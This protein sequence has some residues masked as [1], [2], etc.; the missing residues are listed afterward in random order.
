MRLQGFPALGPILDRRGPV[1]RLAAGILGPASRPVRAILF[2]KS[3]AANWSLGWHQDRVIVV[4]DRIEVE[5]FGPWTIKAGLLH[6]MPPATILGSMLT[7]RVHLDPVAATN[8]PL[9]VAP[10]SHRLG[11]IAEADIPTVVDRCG[12][13]TCLAD[14]GDVWIYSTPILHASEAAQEPKRRRV[15]QVD[16]AASNLPGGLCWLGV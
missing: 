10:G 6:V 16:F 5:G 2:D 12:R 7:L 8:A 13:L 9:L 4:K 3:P 14:T 15:L 11:R 1:G